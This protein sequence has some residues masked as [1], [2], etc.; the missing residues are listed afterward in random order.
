MKKITKNGYI[1]VAIGFGGLIILLNLNL[2]NNGD[3]PVPTQSEAATKSQPKSGYIADLKASLDYPPMRTPYSHMQSLCSEEPIE[4]PLRPEH[5][6][7]DRNQ[8]GEGR[9]KFVF[10]P[11]ANLK[12]SYF[13]LRSLKSVS[14][15]GREKADIVDNTE[16]LNLLDAKYGDRAVTQTGTRNFWPSIPEDVNFT[17]IS[18]GCRAYFIN[19]PGRKIVGVV[20]KTHQEIWYETGIMYIPN[21]A[22]HMD[23]EVVESEVL[24]SSKCVVALVISSTSEIREDINTF[25]TEYRTEVDVLEVDPQF[26][27]LRSDFW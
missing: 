22:D 21:R 18:Y 11:D 19:Q 9:F 27:L 7:C 12:A 20:P 8:D 23:F 10:G 24:G 25:K 1:A 3:E 6:Q 2:P 4:S 14:N 16:V 13:F 15:D 5:F 26:K 17:A